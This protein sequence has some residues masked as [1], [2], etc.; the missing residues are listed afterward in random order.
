LLL[1]ICFNAHSAVLIED[2]PFAEDD[3][4]DGPEAIYRLYEQVSYNC[5]LASGL[6]ALLGAFSLLQSRLHKR[7]EYMVR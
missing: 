4:N 3:F 2:V 1:G 7:K 5:F 6:Y